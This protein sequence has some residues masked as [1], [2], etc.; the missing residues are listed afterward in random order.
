MMRLAMIYMKEGEDEIQCRHISYSCQKPQI[1]LQAYNSYPMD[2][3]VVSKFNAQ[4]ARYDAGGKNKYILL[5][6]HVSEIR[7]YWVPS[8]RK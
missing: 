6:N 2:I 7:T 8:M 5:N 3:Q 1:G 4:T